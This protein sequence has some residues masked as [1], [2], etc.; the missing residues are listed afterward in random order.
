MPSSVAHALVAVTVAAALRPRPTPRRFW[1]PVAVCAVVPDL[2]AIGW[3]FGL[4]DIAWLGGHRALTHSL[5]F[6]GALGAAIGTMYT[7]SPEW[8]G[9][10]VRLCITLAIA[11]ATHG[12]L[13][14]MTTYGAGVA[15]FAPLWWTRYKLDWQPFTGVLTEVLLLWL[16]A[17]CLLRWAPFARGMGATVVDPAPA[18]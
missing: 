3:P 10:R 13:D 15:F 11:T 9:I 18:A 5:L 8:R 6:A 4:P 14:A 17:A 2:D 16:P 1:L 7:R 12:I